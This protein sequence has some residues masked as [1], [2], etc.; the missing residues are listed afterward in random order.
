MNHLL[1]KLRKSRQVNI[2]IGGFTFIVQRPTQVDFNSIPREKGDY[3]D[4]GKKKTGYFP[5]VEPT[6]RQFV[7][8]WQGVKE[9]DLIPGGD[10]IPAEFDAE[11]LVE[12]LKDKQAVWSALAVE[13]WKS[14]SDN[15]KR[16]ADAMG[17]AEA[18]SN[19]SVS[20]PASP[21]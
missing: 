6:I 14:Y 17:E 5:V 16:I 1:E 10:S 19:Q 21:A 4:G 2:E 12:W 3:L 18:G 15:N 8:G 11:V 20:Q 13:I 7:V 9:I